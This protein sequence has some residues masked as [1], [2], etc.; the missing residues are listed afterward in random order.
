MRGTLSAAVIELAHAPVGAARL[1]SG[2]IEQIG[3]TAEA[4]PQSLIEP[5]AGAIA[6]DVRMPMPRRVAATHRTFRQGSQRYRAMYQLHPGRICRQLLNR[7]LV[8]FPQGFGPQL[9][10]ST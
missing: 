5:I 2:Q 10:M 9:A 7:R 8:M 1:Y 6:D 4:G 3:A